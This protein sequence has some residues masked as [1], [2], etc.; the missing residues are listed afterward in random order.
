MSSINNRNVTSTDDQGICHTVDNNTSVNSSDSNLLWLWTFTVNQTTNFLR[1]ISC[2]A[3]AIIIIT[4]CLMLILLAKMSQCLTKWKQW[5]IC[6][7]YWLN[8]HFNQILTLYQFKKCKFDWHKVYERL[9]LGNMFKLIE[10]KMTFWDYADS[11]YRHPAECVFR[12]RSQK[13]FVS[14]YADNTYSIEPHTSSSNPD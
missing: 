7:A 1:I 9:L 14:K 4:W 11:L 3:C 6:G 2:I 13:F 12:S 8:I 5:L 10:Q